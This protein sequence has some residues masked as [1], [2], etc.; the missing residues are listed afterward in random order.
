[1]SR[2]DADTVDMMH[3]D[4]HL[5]Q[6]G[7]KP[8]S[9]LVRVDVAGLSHQGK[10]REQ[11]EDHFLISRFGR[12]LETLDSN[13]PPGTVPARATE[14]GYGLIVADGIGGKAGGEL[15][16]RI[17][18]STLVKLVLATPDWIMR[19]DDDFHEQIVLERARERGEQISAALVET[20]EAKPS[21]AGLGTTM[22]LATSLGMDLF[23]AH[24]GDSRA[25]IFRHGHLHQIT[26]DH[27]LAQALADQGYIDQHEVATHRLRH[28]LTKALSATHPDA[29]PDVRKFPLEDGDI[30][31]LCTDGLTDMVT[32]DAITAT[33][34]RGEKASVICQQLVEQALLGGGKDNVTVIVARYGF[35]PVSQ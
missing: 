8:A 4:H 13:L 23:I 6:S 28:V 30:L 11:N 12:Y 14:T 33:L 5:V 3:P 34:A 32:N 2:H 16:S 26:R 35:P 31:L 1:M 19:L 20:A 7:W 22:T 25:Y 24:I 9:A 27:T 18:I 10:V 29:Q 21:L 15:A 17:A